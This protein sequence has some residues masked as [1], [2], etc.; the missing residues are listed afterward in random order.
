VQDGRDAPV[1]ARPWT[2]PEA[3]A[4]LAAPLARPELPEPPLLPCG[5]PAFACPGLAAPCW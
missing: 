2:A 1:A 5:C 4:A 3:P